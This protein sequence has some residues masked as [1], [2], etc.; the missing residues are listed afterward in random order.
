MTN[1]RILWEGRRRT[2]PYI[3]LC[4]LSLLITLA[5]A[6]L[7]FRLADRLPYPPQSDQTMYLYGAERF[8]DHFIFFWRAPVYGAWMGVFYLLSGC[9]PQQCFYLEKFASLVLLSLLVAGLG[10]RLFDFYS[11]VLMGFWVLNCKYLVLET[12]GSSVMAAALFTL[13]LHC[14]VMRNRAAGVPAALLSMFLSTQVRSEMWVP[15]VFIVA[16]LAVLIIRRRLS[17]MQPPVLATDEARG[18][19][20]ISAVISIGL[21]LLFGIRSSPAESHRFSEAFAMNFAMNY[22][23]RHHLSA[24]LLGNDGWKRVWADAL[25]GVAK[26]GDAVEIDASEIQLFAAVRRY[27]REM[28]NHVGYNIRLAVLALP[29]V[30]LAFDRQG[31]MIFIFVGYLCLL[32]FLKDE[33]VRADRWNFLPQ[34]SRHLVIIWSLAICL[35]VPISLV[36]RVVA[37]YYIQLIPIQIIAAVFLL[38]AACR[39]VRVIASRP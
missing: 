33:D 31:M 14:L 37:R 13:S 16:C 26:A 18:Y 6:V 21:A 28:I 20:A 38:R 3:A 39:K 4:V 5:M 17:R 12:N 30:F 10:Y 29:A 9:D 1:W 15:L 23:D 11:G 2:P 22:V 36:L 32:A 34:E 7:H 19:W 8:A 25:P 24:E 27:P 35:L